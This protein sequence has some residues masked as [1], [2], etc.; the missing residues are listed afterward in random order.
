MPGQVVDVVADHTASLAAGAAGFL[1]TL[2]FASGQFPVPS[3]VPEWLPYAVSILGP[4]AAVVGTRI[5]AGWAAGKRRLAE[6]QRARAAA[7]LADKDKSNDAE[8]HQLEDKADANEAVADVL[9]AVGK[10]KR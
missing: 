9:D 10:I 3:G 4:V 6:K 2:G 1:A 5:L 7:L 8:A